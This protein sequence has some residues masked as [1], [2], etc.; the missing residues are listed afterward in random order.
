MI[1]NI[2]ARIKL[3]T[4]PM[5]IT[6][7]SF[8]I[9]I[10]LACWIFEINLRLI[11]VNSM[12]IDAAAVALAT[13]LVLLVFRNRITKFRTK[14]GKSDF[15]V[16][17]YIFSIALLAAPA[18]SSMHYL[19][20]EMG[21]LS[22]VT[23]ITE[24][25]L[26]N[27]THYYK[28][29]SVVF[30]KG[31][32]NAKW[33]SDI[34]GKSHN[35]LTVHGDFVM[36]MEFSQDTT[37]KN[38]S[39]WCGQTFVESFSMNKSENEL[40]ASISNYSVD[41]SVEFKKISEKHPKY[42][43]L[44]KPTDSRFDE[45]QSA[46]RES[47][48]SADKYLV[49][50]PEYDDF[51]SR[52]TLPFGIMIASFF[53]L[54]LLWNLLILLLQFK[55]PQDKELTSV[56][57]EAEVE[58]RKQVRKISHIFIPGERFKST[59]IILYA[60]ILVFLAMV[61]SG[62]GFFQF[63][64]ISLYKWGAN[65]APSVGDGEFWRLFTSMFLHGGFMHLLFNA[66]GLLMVGFLL[67]PIIGAKRFAIT[68]VLCGL[69]GSFA[70]GVVNVSIISVGASGAIF[71]MFGAL[72]SL[73]FT[74]VF[75]KEQRKVMMANTIVFIVM[76]IVNGAKNPTIDNACHIGGL[77]TGFALGFVI[78]SSIRNQKESKENQSNISELS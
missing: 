3:F 1:N 18:I 42:Y 68:Y 66:Y 32:I 21:G 17:F 24:I 51:E 54:S 69:A 65:Y 49:L 72:L 9:V 13:G 47:K 36:P 19:R 41:K 35:Q 6:S 64:P 30:V 14:K 16:F 29:D 15:V 31:R 39:I 34:T 44:L 75:P 56:E 11:E 40:K 67:E 62:L 58:A 12:L 2:S 77:I 46:V 57:L 10:S 23:N 63:D 28:I 45:M 38:H 60:N 7:V 59:P 8:L 55:D 70:S 73:S 78:Y 25:N 37:K 4:V 22:N 20:S 76:N 74:K 61:F 27:P 26:D 50:V 43:R 48:M 33:E 71:G 53:G 52:S 5:L